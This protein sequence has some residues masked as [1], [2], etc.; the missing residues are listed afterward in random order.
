[1]TL[2][3]VTYLIFHAI[4]GKVDCTSFAFSDPLLLCREGATW[5]IQSLQTSLETVGVVRDL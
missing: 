3:V 5:P 1:M 4:D 2:H